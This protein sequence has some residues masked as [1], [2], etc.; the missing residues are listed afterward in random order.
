MAHKIRTVI[1]VI[2]I[3]LAVISGPIPLVQ[4]WIFFAAA[5]AILGTDHVIIKWCFRQIERAKAWVTRWRKT[6]EPP[7]P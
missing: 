3:I 4:G 2:L 1:G 5:V 7:Q 6:N